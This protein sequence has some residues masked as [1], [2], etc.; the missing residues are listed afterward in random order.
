VTEELAGLVAMERTTASEDLHD[1]INKV[2]QQLNIPVK[3]L[4]GVVTDGAPFM[5]GK[6]S[7]LSMLITKD[8]KNTRPQFVVYHCSIHEE[9]LCAKSVK[10]ANAVIIFAKLNNKD[11]T[12]PNLDSFRGIWILR[13]QIYSTIQKYG[14]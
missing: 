14:G 13:M 1:E 10:T 11:W 6:I 9:N 2:L 3:K 12:I 5:A 4:V 8:V 7:G